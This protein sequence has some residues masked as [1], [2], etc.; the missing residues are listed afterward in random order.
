VKAELSVCYDTQSIG[1]PVHGISVTAQASDTNNAKKGGDREEFAVTLEES[2]TG[3]LP[4]RDLGTRGI[5]PVTTRV[6]R[7]GRHWRRS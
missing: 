6:A 4:S 2:V 3:F 7:L 1:D 5:P